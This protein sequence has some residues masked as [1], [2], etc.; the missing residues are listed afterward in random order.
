[1]GH[2]AT[3]D[4]V[5]RKDSLIVDAGR[6]KRTGTACASIRYTRVGRDTI[7]KRRHVSGGKKN[8]PVSELGDVF[9]HRGLCRDRRAGNARDE[10]FLIEPRDRRE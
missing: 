8:L 4:R 6:S 10:T 3:V 2:A 5:E 7:R 9:P 1:M